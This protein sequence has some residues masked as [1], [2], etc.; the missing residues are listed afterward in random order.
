MLYLWA[1]QM[2]LEVKNK[3]ANAG[4]LR[5]AGS[6]TGLGRSPGGG[7]ANLLMY[8]CLENSMDRGAWQAMVHKVAKS[9]THLLF[10]TF[11]EALLGKHCYLHFINEETE[12]SKCQAGHMA[13]KWP[14]WCL[15]LCQTGYRSLHWLSCFPNTGLVVLSKSHL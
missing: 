1:S 13:R 3:P 6:V 10:L 11:T 14:S 12:A 7:H 9:Q 8:S 4:H 2:A 15:N 5:D